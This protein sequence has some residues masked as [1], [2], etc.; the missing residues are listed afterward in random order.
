MRK[1]GV[2]IGRFQVPH[3]HNGHVEFLKNVLVRCD[4]LL[5]LI[6]VSPVDGQTSRN[7]LSYQQRKEVVECA[8]RRDAHP[9]YMPLLDRATNE[10]WSQ[11]LD[12]L[13]TS[14]F[15]VD[16]VTLYAG[17]H[18]SFEKCYSGRYPVEKI[19][20]GGY[21]EASGT[22]LRADIQESTDLQFIRGQVYALT[23]Q[24]PHG[25]ACV[26]VAV[27]NRDSVL[28]IQRADN[29]EWGLPG[30]FVDPAK[31]ESYEY[32]A[33]REL[34]EETGLTFSSGHKDLRYVG[35]FRVND[36]RYRGGP[37]AIFTTLFIV[38]YQFG[39]VQLNTEECRAFH[40]Y[41]LSNPSSNPMKIA[42][43]HVPLVDAIT[44]MWRRANV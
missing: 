2:V 30:G 6:G 15:P 22:A 27:T 17:A 28:L 16:H 10:E 40:W 7:P 1:I 42:P 4:Q 44:E 3:L 20:A 31:D 8:I 38:P 5:V 21:V 23:R 18:D 26:D 43:V 24:Y 33:A 34:F 39:N 29:G 35:S 12:E 19:E 36:W 25:Y 14:L 9:L 13:L 41:S 11:R 32:A 37:D